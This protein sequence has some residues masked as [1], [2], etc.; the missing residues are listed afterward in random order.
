MITA[1][2]LEK[3][4]GRLVATF[5]A[6]CAERV[7]PIFEQGYPEDPRPREAIAAAREWLRGATSEDRL[8]RACH[9]GRRAGFEPR[10]NHASTD[11]PGWLSGLTAI[12]A[13]SAANAAF[14][15]ANAALHAA[16]DAAMAVAWAADAVLDIANAAAYASP[17]ERAWQA[18]RL[19][20]LEADFSVQRGRATS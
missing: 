9:G 5:A 12:D 10:G 19:A 2:R 1:D 3:L 6:D 17:D 15:A 7:L 4:P 13:T 16:D 14:S 18:E 11:I 20:A 8:V